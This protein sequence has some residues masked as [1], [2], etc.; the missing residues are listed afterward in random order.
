MD[1][2]NW[3]LKY[4]G[5]AWKV[6]KVEI[7]LKQD[8]KDWRKKEFWQNIF[9][10]QFTLY[11]SW[12]WI[13]QNFLFLSSSFYMHHKHTHTSIFRHTLKQT[14]SKKNVHKYTKG[15]V[16]TKAIHRHT[17]VHT[18]NAHTIRQTYNTYTYISKISIRKEERHF[19]RKCN[20]KQ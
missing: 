9:A 13:P 19:E 8:E 3:P 4:W 6:W 12:I 16:Q 17:D 2:A 15:Y 5:F 14:E 10:G 1:V 7:V 20:T 11:V 18:A